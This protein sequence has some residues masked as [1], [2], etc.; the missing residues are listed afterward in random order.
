M[1]D[2]KDKKQERINLPVTEK[3]KSLIEIIRKLKH[4]EIRVIIQDE[5]PVRIENIRES[6]V[7]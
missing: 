5:A 6:I 7:L 4:G 1:A 3:E 2:A